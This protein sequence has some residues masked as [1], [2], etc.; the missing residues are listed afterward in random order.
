MNAVNTANYTKVKARELQRTLYLAAKANAKRRFHSLYDKVYRSDVLWEAWRRVKAN[1]G[2]AGVDGVTIRH[3][4]EEY[5]EEQF[6]RETQDLLK[7]GTYRPLPV[8]RKNIPKADGKERPLGIP[9]IQDRLVQMASKMV[10]EPIFEAD[11]KDCSFGFRPKRSAKDAIQRIQRTVNYENTYWA[12]DVDIS[13]Y[14]NNI[15][16]DKLLML[17]KQRVSD[18]RVLKLIRQWLKAGYVEEGLFHETELGS[19]QGGVISPLLANIY[20]NYLDTV[21]ERNYTHLGKLVRYADDLVILC[22]KKADALKAIQVLKAVFQRLELRMNRE[23]SKLVSLWPGKPG[24]DFLG[25]H[26]RYMPMMRPGGRV[27]NAFRSYPSKKS[28]KK[29]R[30]RVR[31]E[32]APR[33]R[34]YWTVQQVVSRLNPII[35]GWTNY[36]TAA[37][38]KASRKFLAKID[39]HISRRLILYW[40][41]KYKRSRKSQSEIMKAFRGMGLKSVTGYGA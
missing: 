35:Q 41:K 31:E 24:F 39:W 13:G 9:V 14:F 6:V 32:L 5:G 23:K 36:Y 3:I 28:M 21:W 18:R 33:N 29:M 1:R 38:P 26:H 30:D 34:L 27:W 19:P 8:R 2:S 37:D 11:F 15:P 20:L 25:H 12:V 40:R 10:L 16:H 4:V 7:K 22:H 17:V